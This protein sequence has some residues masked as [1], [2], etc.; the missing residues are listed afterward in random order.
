MMTRTTVLALQGSSRGTS[1]QLAGQQPSVVQQLLTAAAQGAQHSPAFGEIKIR[2]EQQLR[3]PSCTITL[4]QLACLAALQ[5]SA[6][7]LVSCNMP[8]C[9]Q[10][11]CFA[12]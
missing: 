3:L 5:A 12:V 11:G 8:W 6:A 4:G 2:C 7:Q 1:I 9:F 10:L